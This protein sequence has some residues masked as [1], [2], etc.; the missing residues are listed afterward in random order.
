VREL[1]EFTTINRMYRKRPFEMITISL[2]APA[3][4]ESAVKEL[5]AAHVSSKN[6]QFGADNLDKLAEALDAKWEGP[7]PHTVLIAPGGEVIY[8]HTGAIEPLELKRAIVNYLGRT[9]AGKK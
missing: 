6:Y 7:V 1:P 2:D 8:R 4:K 9:Y 5:Q 3:Q